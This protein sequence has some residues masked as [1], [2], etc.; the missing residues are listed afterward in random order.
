MSEVFR[1]LEKEGKKIIEVE[2]ITREG[3]LKV[4]YEVNKLSLSNI[5]NKVIE[6]PNSYPN[7]RFFIVKTENEKY[8]WELIREKRSVELVSV[9]DIVVDYKLIVYPPQREK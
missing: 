9:N 1:I 3:S 5:L 6:D 2:L 8:L 7:L 4:P